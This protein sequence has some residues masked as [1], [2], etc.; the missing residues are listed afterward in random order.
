MFAHT[1]SYARYKKQS[2]EMLDFA[3]VVCYAIPSLKMQAKVVK[4]GLVGTN[5]PRP[6]YFKENNSIDDVLNKAA[7]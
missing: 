6:D 7:K 4:Q 2:Q 5:L 3:V 1:Q